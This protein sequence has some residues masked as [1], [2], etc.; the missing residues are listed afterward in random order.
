MNFYIGVT[1]T[2]WYHYLRYHNPEDINFWQPGGTPGF[3]AIPRGAPFLL[4]MKYPANAISG[5]GF[6]ISHAKLP[7]SLAWETF[8][9]RNGCD[10]LSDLREAI[11]K[12]RRGKGQVEHDPVIGCIILTD[13]VFFSDEDWIPAPE[14]WSKNIVAGKTY[15]TDEY[16]GKKLWER[17]N[18][19]LVKYRFYEKEVKESDVLV[20]EE[21]ILNRY[22]E[23]ITKVRIGQG[24]FRLLVTEA[25]TRRCAV[26]GEKTLPVLEAAHIKPY[27]E[28]G[29]H[30]IKNGLLLRSDL[31]KLFDNGYMTVT[32]DYYVEVS[33]QIKEKYKNGREYYRYHGNNLT[34][35]PGIDK[36]KPGAGYLQWHNE[37][38]Y[39]G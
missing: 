35:L 10:T 36:E 13:P 15:S 39:Q 29:P 33:N 28:S 27:A 7:I 25:Y 9:N 1:D 2:E 24:T 20:N 16:Y 30:A 5:V 3:K 21:D 18:D 37:N 19:L 14:N 8:G 32:P 34:V 23:Y 17:V 4:K 38:V 12:Y 26:T 6:F 22:G 11:M 31:H